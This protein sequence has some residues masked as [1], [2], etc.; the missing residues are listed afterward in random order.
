MENKTCIRCLKPKNPT[1][2][3]YLASNTKMFADGRTPVCK[4]CI[5][6]RMLTD[7]LED[8][9]EV[10]RIIDKPF[11]TDLWKIAVDSDVATV[12][13]YFSLI[14]KVD[15]RDLTWKHSILDVKAELGKDDSSKNLIDKWGEGFT[16]EE[17]RS[18]EKKYQLLINNYSEKTAMHTEALFTY[19]RYKVKAELATARG[20]VKEAKEW[21]ALSEKAATAAKINPSQFSKADLSDGLD[22]VGQIVRATEQHEDIIPILP[23]FKSRPQ[24]KVDFNLWCYINYVRDLQGLPLV[25]YEDVYAFYDQRKKEYAQNNSDVD[26]SEL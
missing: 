13:K 4:D 16:A 1:I 12:G 26:E 18:F 10:L 11:M 9:Y 15:T 2:G 19:I 24:D 20:E 8:K 14:G 7:N 22:S 17:Y 5:K 6:E 23:Q 3:F 25:E 21:G